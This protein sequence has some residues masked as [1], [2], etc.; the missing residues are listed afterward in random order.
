MGYLTVILSVL[1]NLFF[2]NSALNMINVGGVSPNLSLILVIMFTLLGGRKLGCTLAVIVGLLQDLLFQDIIGINAMAFFLIALIIGG[3]YEKFFKANILIPLAI[4]A[5]ST[6]FYY[7]LILILK[8]L[9]LGETVS[10]LDAS[11][12]LA[13]EMAY[14]GIVFTLVY[15]FMKKRYKR[16]AARFGKSA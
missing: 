6:M 15:G 8:Y 1:I 12:N 4:A 2:G 7:L 13:I 11:Y 3:A 5:L 14:N 9:I 16:S 10:L